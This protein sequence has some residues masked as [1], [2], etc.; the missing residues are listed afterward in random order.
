MP[1]FRIRSFLVWPHIHLSMCI[2]ATLN[3]WPCRLLVSQ[4][5]ALYNIAGLIVILQ[6]LPF[7]FCGTLSSQRTP[8]A[9]RHFIHPALIRW[10]TSSLMSPSFCSIDLKYRKVSF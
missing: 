2:S 8:E 3:H 1:S 9:W 7:N 5:S 10:L 4:H 6:N